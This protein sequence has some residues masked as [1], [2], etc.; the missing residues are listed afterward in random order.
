MSTQIFQTQ[1]IIL[2]T[3]FNYFLNSFHSEF[4]ISSSSH[5]V[6]IR[7]LNT[8][9]RHK[10]TALLYSRCKLSSSPQLV[11]SRSSP[12]EY[13][14]LKFNYKSL[15]ITIKNVSERSWTIVRCVYKTV[16]DF[17]KFLL[18]TSEVQTKFNL[19]EKPL[20]KLMTRTFCY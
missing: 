3:S 10:I 19:P 5:C 8:Q 1:N 4:T 17:R 16:D 2:Q 7:V 9:K 18:L 13:V 14:K 20:S 12:N 11:N 15:Y 6:E